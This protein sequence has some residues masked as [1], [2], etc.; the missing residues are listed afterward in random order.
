LSITKETETIDEAP[1]IVEVVQEGDVYFSVHS[2]TAEAEQAIDLVEGER[3]YVLETPN[4][5]WWFVKKHLT[6]EKGWV[7]AQI[8]MDEPNYTIYVQKKLNEKIDKLPVFE[9]K[10]L[11]ISSAATSNQTFQNPNQK[12]NQWRHASSKNCNPS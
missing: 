10:Y 1:E 9:S 6:E 7:P 5:D 12:K 3:I 11:S 4:S 2:Y 8:L